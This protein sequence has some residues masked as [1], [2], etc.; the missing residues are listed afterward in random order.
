MSK[1]EWFEVTTIIVLSM[2]VWFC[3]ALFPFNIQ[4]ANLVLLF[5]GLLLLQSL[6]RDISILFIQRKVLYSTPPRVVPCMCF[7]SA[8]GIT[9]VLTGVG[10]I[11]LGT[12]LT[13]KMGQIQWTLSVTAI[14]ITGFLIKDLVFQ[15]NPWKIYKEKDHLNIVFSWKKPTSI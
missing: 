11:G 15:W 2:A 5:S 13:I 4:I 10:L 12:A 7:E 1:L 14:T 3:A 8:I 6:L 9:G